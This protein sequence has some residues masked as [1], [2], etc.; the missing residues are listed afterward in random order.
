MFRSIKLPIT[1]LITAVV[2][3]SVVATF[4]LSARSQDD[5]IEM[6]EKQ[7]VSNLSDNIAMRIASESD[8]SRQNVIIDRELALLENSQAIIAAYIFDEQKRLLGS[9]GGGRSEEMKQLALKHPYGVLADDDLILSVS[10]IGSDYAVEGTVVVISDLSD[11]K[12]QSQQ[13]LAFQTLP[14]LIAVIIIAVVI[15]FLIIQVLL[16]PLNDL[17]DFTRKISR[18]KD[19]TARFL[20]GKS[21]EISSL[22]GNINSFLDTIEVELTINKE[23][24]ATLVEQQ[25]TMMRLANYDSL[26]ALPNRQFVVDNLRLELAATRRFSTHLF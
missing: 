1:L 6:L 17:I 19:Y 3:V 7:K 14:E 20:P 25:Q 15:A 4:Y 11:V 9:S 22:V 2:S 16:K 8:T 12:K 26:T 21:R 13:V 24:N 10:E 23:Q 18:N 5:R